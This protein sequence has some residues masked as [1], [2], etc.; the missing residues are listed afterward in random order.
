MRSSMITTEISKSKFRNACTFALFR[1]CTE[2]RQT[3]E[4]RRYEEVN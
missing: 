4:S 1:T 3:D 2:S